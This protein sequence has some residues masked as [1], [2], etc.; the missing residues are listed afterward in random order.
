MVVQIILG[1]VLLAALI[2]GAL[3]LVLRN[4]EASEMW[5]DTRHLVSD[6]VKSFR[7]GELTRREDVDD[8]SL[9]E[10][11]RSNVIVGED[12]VQLPPRLHDAADRM[13]EAVTKASESVSRRLATRSK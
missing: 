8:V 10:F 5:G 6:S 3:Y 11:F 2:G 7:E 12:D 13:G 9:G 1:L 4:D